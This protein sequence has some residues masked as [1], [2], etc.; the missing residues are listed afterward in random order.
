[1]VPLPAPPSQD[2]H[3]LY[4]P[5]LMSPNRARVQREN[6][7][8]IWDYLSILIFGHIQ[9]TRDA[10]PVKLEVKTI[11][12][13]ER[14]FLDWLYLA[15]I[16]FGLGVTQS[17]AVPEMKT[18]GMIVSVAALIVIPW[19]FAIFYRRQKMMSTL[20]AVESYSSNTGVALVMVASVLACIG[21]MTAVRIQNLLITK[22]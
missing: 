11:L 18:V 13:N 22:Q 12:A 9:D 8:S 15:F 6:Q 19:V 1:L 20:R 4:S 3:D 10:E 2:D 17:K 5:L 16:S 7:R 21:L 14:T